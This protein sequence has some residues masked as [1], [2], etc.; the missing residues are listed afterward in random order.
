LK[1]TGNYPPVTKE[2][3]GIGNAGKI[4]I[5][6]P[7][8]R[9]K[10]SKHMLKLQNFIIEQL[11]PEHDF[12]LY[13]FPDAICEPNTLKQ[14]IKGMETYSDAGWFGGVLH[15]R[16]PRHRRCTC[17]NLSHRENIPKE[18]GIGSPYMK[19]ETIPQNKN[20]SWYIDMR[21]YKCPYYISWLGEDEIIER[22]L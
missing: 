11:K 10:I 9:D 20:P 21:K 6:D 3:F 15:R 12:I 7:I 4:N 1:I 13:W 22:Q 8:L 18:Y 16:F 19:F 2:I 14:Y 5:E 17:K